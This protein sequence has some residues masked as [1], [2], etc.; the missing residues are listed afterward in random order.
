MTIVSI[1]ALRVLPLQGHIL[2]LRCSLW[3]PGVRD[4][5]CSACMYLYKSN[6]NMKGT[7]LSVLKLSRASTSIKSGVKFLV[8]E[9]Y[10]N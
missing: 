6:G 4:L 7:F 5:H 9:L 1:F 2:A 8:Y 3:P 10:L